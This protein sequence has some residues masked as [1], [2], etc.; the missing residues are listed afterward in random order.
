M[1]LPIHT[2]ELIDGSSPLNA[3]RLLVG[4]KT[5]LANAA[6]GGADQIVTTTVTFGTGKL[7]PVALYGVNIT[8]DQNCTHWV[9]NRTTAGFDVVLKPP[10]GGTLAAGKFD[11]QVFA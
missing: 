1:P 6:G 2:L 3:D 11:V 9:N 7:P 8:P 4:I 5:Q 10:S